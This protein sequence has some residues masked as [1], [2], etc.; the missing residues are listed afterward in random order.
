MFGTLPSYG[1]YIRH[2]EGVTVSNVKI[3]CDKPDQRPAVSMDDVTDARFRF[4][5][6]KKVAGVPLYVL[7]QVKGFSVFQSPPTPDVH[8]D[9]LSHGSY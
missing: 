4:M 8:V 3:R 2:A 5:D 9:E 7:K 6:L 1:F